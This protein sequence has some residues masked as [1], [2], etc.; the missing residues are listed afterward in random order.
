MKMSDVPSLIDTD[1]VEKRNYQKEIF[2]SIKNEDSLVVLPTGLGKTIIAIYLICHRLEEGKRA[3]IMAPSRPLCK[4]HMDL[5]IDIT[6]LERKDVELVTGELYSPKQ[7]KS[8]W[9]KDYRVFIATPQVVN[10]DLHQLPIRSLGLFVFDEVHRATGDYAYTEIARACRNKVQ[11]L[12]MTAS[13][14]SSFESLVQVC[15]N[16][17]I[18]HI[19]VR[20]ESD[21]DVRPYVSDR[22]IEWTEIEKSEPVRELESLLDKMLDHFLTEL[23]DYSKR[24][25]NLKL[26]SIGKSTLVDIQKNLQ[27]RIKDESKGYL[28]HALSLTSAC[29]KASHLKE[30]LLTQGIDASYRYYLKILDDESR[31]SKYIVKRD[32][33]DEVG[34]RLIDLKAM[35]V[36]TDP[37]LEKTRE[38]LGNRSMDGNV[39]VFARYRDTVDQLVKELDRME[40]IYPAKLIGQSDKNGDKGMSQEEQKDTLRKFEDHDKN[41]LV[42]TSIGEEGLDIPSTDL[43]IFYEPVPSAIRYIQR[44]GRTGRNNQPGKVHI[45]LTKDSKDEIFHWKS[46]KEEKRVYGHV[47]RLKEKLEKADDTSRF[48]EKLMDEEI[49]GQKRLENYG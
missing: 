11:F 39:M 28:F 7:R 20:E 26:D 23:G 45:L 5:L 31:S 36:E 9:A 24:A 35:P 37:K 1:I 33:F 16:L 19:E 47:Y 29:I 27:K 4:Q 25:K 30:L 49:E 8:I 42:S 34:D 17:D 10:N 3:L 6:G 2:E 12:G 44:K 48:L 15:Y 14:G 18:D 40:D 38:L 41:V 13:P 21:E 46:M 22:S 32:E 43:V